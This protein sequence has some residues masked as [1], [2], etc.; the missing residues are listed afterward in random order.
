M[1]SSSD[2][3]SDINNLENCCNLRFWFEHLAEFVEPFVWDWYDCFVGFD[4]AER[5]VLGGDIEVGEYVVGG[6]F[7]DVGKS[8][9]AHFEC[10]ARSSP[11]YLLRFLLLLLFGRHVVR[12]I[13]L[14]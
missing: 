10:V 5:V 1:G 8:D 14:R 9:D 11:E 4:G 7:A 2:D 13:L 12:N 3:T 6:G